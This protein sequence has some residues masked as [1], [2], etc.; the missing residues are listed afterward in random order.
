MEL[1]Y[2]PTIEDKFGGTVW[3]VA[4]TIYNAD[5]P[6]LEEGIFEERLF[7]DEQEARDL[8]D[9]LCERDDIDDIFDREPDEWFD[10]IGVL[11]YI[12]DYEDGW[13]VAY[14][15]YFTGEIIEEKSWSR[16]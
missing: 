2:F 7:D 5:E 1:M 8:F 12:R 4:T 9:E 13:R 11:L 10:T 15:V 14:D 3:A 16:P 6:E